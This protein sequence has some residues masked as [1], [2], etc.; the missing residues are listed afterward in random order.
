MHKLVRLFAAAAILL[1]HFATTAA[2]E[3][4]VDVALDIYAKPQQL[5][6]IGGRNL[7][8]RCSGT[9]AT[10]VLLEAGNNADSMTWSKLQPLVAKFAHVCS[11]D[12]AGTGFSDGGPLPRNVDTHAD[13][14]AA[15][16]HSAHIA[17]PL[18]LVGHS[19]GTNI[20]RRFA[21]KHPDQ[22]AAIVLLD[23]PPQ[24]VAEF[25]PDL[26]KADDEEQEQELA[27][28][29]K[30]AEGA[31]KGQLDAPPPELKPCLRGPNPEFSDALNAAQHA[32]K[33]RPAFW[34]TIISIK[35][36]NNALYKQPVSA[37]EKH[38]AIPLLVLQPDAP[39]GDMPAEMRKPLEAAREK[40]QKA[41][42]ATSSKGKIIAVARSS[43]DVQID[44]PDAVVAAIKEALAK[45]APAPRKT[46]AA[47]K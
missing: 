18:V 1:C 27:I 40:T 16:L 36:T 17:T 32:S 24:N 45:G 14:L 46:A 20:V 30:C 39:F 26:Q 44:R 23:P 21:D 6:D 19:Y 42:V 25:A 38:G 10:T 22:V 29:R 43:H 4:H 9:G 13:D 5:V 35:Q 12:R 3:A 33:I 34:Q 8:L 7:N 37:Q 41:I 2:A 11:Y 28:I 15:L 31:E 47:T